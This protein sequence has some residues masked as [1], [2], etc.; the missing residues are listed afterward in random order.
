[1]TLA[2]GVVSADGVV[3]AADSRLFLPVPREPRVVSDFN[4]KLFQVGNVAIATFGWGFLHHESTKGTR[5]IAH[6]V[7]DFSREAKITPKTPPRQVA[8]KLSEFFGDRVDL[9]IEKN[10][11]QWPGPGIDSLGFLVAGVRNASSEVHEVLLPSRTRALAVSSASPGVAWRGQEDLM[12]RLWRGIDLARARVSAKELGLGAELNAAMPIF[13]DLVA[14]GFF[15]SMCLQD[16]VDFATFA[17][18]TTIDFQRLTLGFRGTGTHLPTVGGPIEIAMIS[19]WNGEFTW[20]SQKKIEGDRPPGRAE[21][22]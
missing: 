20:V 21:F 1:M 2:V 13:D 17:I 12:L 15:E 11:K 14:E 22:S 9:H 7:I 5:N 4:H 10:P 19:N 3:L 18:R 6:H 16:A 8:E